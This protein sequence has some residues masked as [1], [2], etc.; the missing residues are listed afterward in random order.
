MNTE[1]AIRV[2]RTVFA[3]QK[4]ILLEHGTVMPVLADTPIFDL[5]KD[6]A[7]QLG[8]HSGEGSPLGDV[9]PLQ[10]K[11]FAGYLVAFN[12]PL[13]TFVGNDELIEAKLL[14]P[15]PTEVLTHSIHENNRGLIEHSQIGL[16]G[17][18]KR[19]KDIRNPK[20]IARSEETTPS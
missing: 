17:R 20:I 12:F 3:G 5:L 19:N 10:L 11:E 1:L 6:F 15:S 16:F 13:F 4:W 14:A 18:A 9:Q 7:K 8:P 2:C